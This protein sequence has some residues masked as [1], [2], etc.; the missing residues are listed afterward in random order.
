MERDL[1]WKNAALTSLRSRDNC[2]ELVST[3]IHLLRTGHLA[4]DH[5]QQAVDRLALGK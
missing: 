2:S 1:T 4:P 3:F 5:L